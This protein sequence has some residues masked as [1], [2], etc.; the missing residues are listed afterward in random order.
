M[1]NVGAFQESHTIKTRMSVYVNSY[2]LKRCVFSSFLK[3]R[4]SGSARMCSGNE[5]HAARPACDKAC[6]PNLVHSYGGEK[7]IDDVDLRR[8]PRCGR[9]ALSGGQISWASDNEP[10]CVSRRRFVPAWHTIIRSLTT[11]H[12]RKTQNSMMPTNALVCVDMHCSVFN[13]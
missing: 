6:S 2:R 13:V 8:W 9:L 7:S 11:V 1:L 10:W 4:M 12:N 3:T 5:F